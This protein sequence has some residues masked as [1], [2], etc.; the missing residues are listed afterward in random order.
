MKSQPTALQIP[1]IPLTLTLM[2]FSLDRLAWDTGWVTWHYKCV[3][4]KL[5]RQVILLGSCVFVHYFSLFSPNPIITF[6]RDTSNV[7]I[8]ASF[9]SVCCV[10]REK[11][12]F[13]LLVIVNKCKLHYHRPSSEF[14]LNFD[15]LFQFILLYTYW[16]ASQTACWASFLI[17]QRKLNTL[18]DKRGCPMLTF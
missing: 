4:I 1:V 12:L 11:P 8:F 2:C 16:Y 5:S 6:F 3:F 18:N 7:I 10:N 17:S 14:L 13:T 9:M 15:N